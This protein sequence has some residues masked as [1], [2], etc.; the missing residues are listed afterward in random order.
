MEDVVYFM[1]IWSI[2]RPFGIFYGY[3]VHF[4]R[5]GKL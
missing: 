3:L 5:F 1:T 2:V 4:F